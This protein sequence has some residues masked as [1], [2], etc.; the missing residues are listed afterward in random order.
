MCCLFTALVLLGPRFGAI[1]WWIFQ[2]ARWNLAF[3]TVLWPILGIIS[4]PWTTIM[5]VAVAPLGNP[6]GFDWVWLGL[7]AAVDIAGHAGGGF[8]NRNRI[9]GYGSDTV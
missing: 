2:P 7:A 3:N 1:L 8:G 6:T 9:P 5:W 4:L